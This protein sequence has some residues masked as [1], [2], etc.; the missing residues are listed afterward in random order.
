MQITL[1][2]VSERREKRGRGADEMLAFALGVGIL[3]LAKL[4]HI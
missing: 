3:K 1:L 2:K 4:M